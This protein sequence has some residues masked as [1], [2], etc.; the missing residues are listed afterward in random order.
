MTKHLTLLLFI[1]LVWG[2]NQHPNKKES[3]KSTESN[4]VLY[5][6]DDP[7][8]LKSRLRPKIPSSYNGELGL[9]N[10]MVNFMKKR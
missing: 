10:L 7:P 6:Y 1:G 5:A 4:K 8:V 9:V 2:Q 3:K